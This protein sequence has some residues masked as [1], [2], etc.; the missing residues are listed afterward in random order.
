MASE[1]DTAIDEPKAKNKRARR[2]AP[3]AC[4]G[5]RARKVRCDFALSGKPCLNCFLDEADCVVAER[6]RVG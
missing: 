2:R 6:A 1:P 3:Q 4:L 5:C